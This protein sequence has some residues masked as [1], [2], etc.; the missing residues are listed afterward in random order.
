MFI[1]SQ[2]L[3]TAREKKLQQDVLE[4]IEEVF[5]QR[6]N[7]R[8]RM[9]EVESPSNSSIMQRRSFRSLESFSVLPVDKTVKSEQDTHRLYR[10]KMFDDEQHLERS[11]PQI[12][13]I[14]SWRELKYNTKW[15]DEEKKRLS[16]S[17]LIL[18]LH[19][20]LL[21]PPGTCVDPYKVE[22]SL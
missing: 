2:T 8:L 10:R 20:P 19:I 21:K 5:N 14:D 18:L 9:V 12:Q 16:L 1:N 13:I 4:F 3:E 17:P 15:R 22:Y 11:P 6:E 7:S